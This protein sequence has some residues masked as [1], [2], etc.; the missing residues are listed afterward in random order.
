MFVM[1]MVQQTY[2][3][4]VNMLKLLI[5]EYS[6]SVLKLLVH[7][8]VSFNCYCFEAAVNYCFFSFLLPPPPPAFFEWAGV[9]VKI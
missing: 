1:Y 6:L 8:E 4:N 9:P 7:A 2:L 3:D 5:A